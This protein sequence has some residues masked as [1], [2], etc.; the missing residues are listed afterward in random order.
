MTVQGRLP[1]GHRDSVVLQRPSRHPG[2]LIS[3][4]ARRD[5]ALLRA[6]VHTPGWR[7]VVA[8]GMARS[9]QDAADRADGLLANAIAHGVPTGLPKPSTRRSTPRRRKSPPPASEEPSSE[10]GAQ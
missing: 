7:R 2:L 3:V 8:V 6:Y 5:E 9:P 4:V 10:A 1:F